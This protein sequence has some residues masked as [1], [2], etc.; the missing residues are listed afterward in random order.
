MIYTDD[1]IKKKSDRK[2][3]RKKF[4][5]IFFLI[6]LIII[7]I[8][9]CYLG[10]VNFI[11]KS[12]TDLFGYRHFII[13]TGSMEPNYKIGDLIIIKKFPEEEIKIGDVITYNEING[14]E[15]IS[16]R[17]TDIVQENGKKLYQTKGDNNNSPDK[18]LI[19]Y[20]QIQ[21]KIVFKVNNVG[22][23]ITDLTK[24]IGSV[25]ILLIVLISYI[26]ASRKDERRVAREEA[27]IRYNIPKYKEDETI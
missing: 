27:R 17:V 18:D 23:I 26:F 8:V 12:K 15:A 16:H 19:S 14:K 5:E 7:F 10:Y 11:K 1:I 20:N 4:F 2:R 25:I 13:A 21:G 9:A 3:K 24:G 22:N 6:I